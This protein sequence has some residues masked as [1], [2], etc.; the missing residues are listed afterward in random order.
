[1]ELAAP[2]EEGSISRKDS[3]LCHH[4]KCIDSI[5]TPIGYD[6]SAAAYDKLFYRFARRRSYL[7]IDD[8]VACICRVK[9]MTG[10][11]N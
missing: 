6:L 10:N 8:F 2:R 4:E 5:E 11:N 3:L 7:R 1:M 9:I